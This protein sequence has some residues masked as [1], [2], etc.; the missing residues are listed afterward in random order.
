MLDDMSHEHL[1]FRK[2]SYSSGRQEN[3]VEVA[4]FPG[5]AAVRDSQN[6]EDGHLTFA[7]TEWSAL[8]GMI[9]R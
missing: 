1:V 6:P 3:C 9:H 5:G 8:L 4:D 2:S 7:T